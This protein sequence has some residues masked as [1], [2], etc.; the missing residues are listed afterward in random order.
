[1]K[2]P[3][4]KSNLTPSP[5]VSERLSE[6]GPFQGESELMKRDRDWVL[7]MAYAL[8]VDSG[9]NIPI[10]PEPAPFRTLFA[11]IRAGKPAPSEHTAHG[12][13]KSE[14]RDET[15]VASKAGDAQT[16]I[17]LK[18]L[19]DDLLSEAVNCTTLLKT[20]E[21]NGKHL[22]A[23]EAEIRRAI[24]LRASD[25]AGEKAEKVNLSSHSNAVLPP[26]VPETSSPASPVDRMLLPKLREAWES[27]IRL[28]RAYHDN[29][30]HL[31][32]EQKE[33]QWEHFL[34]KHSYPVP[35]SP[36]PAV[37][38]EQRKDLD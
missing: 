5:Q 33:R 7:A 24:W 8:G 30:I 36:A 3:L 17:A 12:G 16:Q 15:P 19:S 1:M 32:G 4:S 28:A 11:E 23:H 25:M 26:P 35:T 10:V 37:Q 20:A 34:T 13:Q 21:R 22:E 38:V 6:V 27:G 29:I 9:F 14:S 31:Q 2:P 18:E